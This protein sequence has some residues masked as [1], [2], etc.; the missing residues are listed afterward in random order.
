MTTPKGEQGTGTW[1]ARSV[2]VAAAAAEDEEEEEEAVKLL[3][4]ACRSQSSSIAT[5][6]VDSATTTRGNEQGADF[7]RADKGRGERERE[8]RHLRRRPL[9]ASALLFLF[10]ALLSGA[11]GNQ[12]WFRV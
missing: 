10:G 4:T 5:S 8:R 9:I 12:R 3:T 1:G 11:R 7:L 6:F 2:D